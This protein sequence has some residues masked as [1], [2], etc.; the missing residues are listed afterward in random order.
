MGKITREAVFQ[1]AEAV[2]AQGQE[3][4]QVKVRK[5]L[6]SGSF[7]DIGPFLKAWH[8]ARGAIR[9][10]ASMDMPD[11]AKNAIAENG[12]ILWQIVSAEAAQAIEAARR[13]FTNTKQTMTDE[14]KDAQEA[15][16][17]LEEEQAQQLSEIASLRQRD[18]ER[19]VALQ[20]M[21]EAKGRAE[22]GLEVALK[23]ITR[24]EGE[25]AQAQG[26]MEQMAK[27]A[28]VASEV[29]QGLQMDLVQKE[30]L[31][32]AATRR[33]DEVER[34][35]DNA[36]LR[37]ADADNRAAQLRTELDDRV[38][39][40]SALRDQQTIMIARYEARITQDQA[41]K[42]ELKQQVSAQQRQLEA[43]R[44]PRPQAN[45]VMR[46]NPNPSGQMT[47]HIQKANP[48]PPAQGSR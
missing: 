44:Q 42:N 8:E 1:A 10:A 39:D 9:P 48:S 17:V 25:L 23:T 26:R 40:V 19:E 47:P 41:D 24:L 11:A 5:L 15:I 7:S 16:R 21:F 36:T 33:I 28:M 43:A 29:N 20:P 30:T 27:E 35:R 3:P 18:A 46:A 12:Q 6:G 13:E 45:P 14:L 37:C 34:D 2:L 38:A 4:S 22:A 32:D 31:L